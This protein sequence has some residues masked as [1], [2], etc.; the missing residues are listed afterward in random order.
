MNC[1]KGVRRE[2]YHCYYFSP[3]AGLRKKVYFSNS[4]FES[5]FSAPQGMTTGYEKVQGQ[6]RPVYARDR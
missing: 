1:P 2:D 6:W 3:E 5:I 4:L